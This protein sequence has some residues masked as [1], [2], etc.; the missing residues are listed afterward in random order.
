M[1]VVAKCTSGPE[2]TVSPDCPS[3]V[4]WGCPNPACGPGPHLRPQGCQPLPQQCRSRAGLHLPTAMSCLAT[5]PQGR[6]THR[7]TPWPSLDPSPGRCPMPTAGA[8]LCPPAA[9]LLA[10][11]VGW[12]CHPRGPLTIPRTL[13]PR[14]PTAQAGP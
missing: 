4:P 2:G 1:L 14:E 5:G 13:F 3:P 12:P 7:P 6:I 9:L 10:G 8:A 11:V